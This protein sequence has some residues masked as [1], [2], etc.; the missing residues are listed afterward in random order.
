MFF[1]KDKWEYTFRTIPTYRDIEELERGKLNQEYNE[2][3]LHNELNELG[4]QGFE[5]CEVVSYSSTTGTGDDMRETILQY[6]RYIFK[7]KV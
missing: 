5:L 6:D 7:R 2:I 4:Q 3:D 1:K